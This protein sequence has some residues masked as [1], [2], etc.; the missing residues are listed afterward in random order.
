MRDLITILI[1]QYALLD[2]AVLLSSDCTALGASENTFQWLQLRLLF[3]LWLVA[4][5]TTASSP[6]KHINELDFPDYSLRTP[7]PLTSFYFGC[8]LFSHKLSVKVLY[9]FQESL[10][11]VAS[12][13]MYFLI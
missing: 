10:S 8:T 3:T 5:S 2:Y 1:W 4:Q 9:T 7:S 13:L 12:P 11:T 6:A